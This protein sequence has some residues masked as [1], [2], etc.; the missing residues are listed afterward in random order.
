MASIHQRPRSP[1][2]HASFLAPDGRWTLRSTKCE[3]RTKAMSV[4]LE[5]ER[6]SKL[7]RAG[8]LVEAQARKVV[9]DIMARA[10]GEETLRAP[11][12]NDF[13]NQWIASKIERKSKGTATRYGVAVTD[14]LA[15][16]GNRTAKPLT[17]LTTGDVERFLSYRT[18]KG[19]APQTL[20][21]D[22]KIIGAALNHARRQGII[23]TNPAEAVELPKGKSMERGTFTPAEV[24]MLVDTA[25]GEWKTLILL[26]YFTG[27]RM[28]DCCRMAWAD[29]DLST[30][31]YTQAK[32]GE[33]VTVP[34]HPDLAAHLGTLAG[35]DKPEVFLM[36]HTANLKSGG[37]KGLSQTFKLIMRD[38]GLDAGKVKKAGVRQLSRRTFHALRHSFN[39]VM[40]NA[41]VSQEVRM[42]LT[43]HKTESVNRG[44]T[45]HELEPL[46][47]AI[48]KIPSLG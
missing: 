34:L 12:V 5:F 27:A 1:Y 41:G 38:A 48:K 15:S 43:G 47:A 14:F 44:Y 2:W 6:A 10:G 20:V 13:L 29:T 30:I 3:D 28:S 46:R 31:T 33:K 24:K 42:K 19:L 32:T 7:G 8:N 45:H 39:S 35:T 21:L 36:P 22:I 9:A 25:K 18:D 11:S 17:S 37:R 23:T 4:A 40:A 26:A 16:L